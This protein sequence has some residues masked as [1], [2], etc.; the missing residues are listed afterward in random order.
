MRRIRICVQTTTKPRVNVRLS[1]PNAPAARRTRGARVAHTPGIAGA[2]RPAAPLRRRPC[3]HYSGIGQRQA[4]TLLNAAPSRRARGSA[5]GADA[6]DA[7]RPGWPGLAARAPAGRRRRRRRRWR[8][9]P[10]LASR[11]APRPAPRPVA[12]R[13]PSAHVIAAMPARVFATSAGVPHI[14]GEMPETAAGDGRRRSRGRA[15][16]VRA[17]AVSERSP[18]APES[19]AG[20]APARPAAPPGMP[21]AGRQARRPYRKSARHASPNS[22]GRVIFLGS[23]CRHMD[24]ILID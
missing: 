1:G 12:R 11:L 2:K 13:P 18:G 17:A 19:A 20:R 5:V 9:G 3:R 8:P 23:C 7:D 4:L 10:G 21:G 14:G 15:R 22:A 24:A 16:R 6:A